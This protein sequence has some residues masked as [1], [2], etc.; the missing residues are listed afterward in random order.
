MKIPV[1][2]SFSSLVTGTVKNLQQNCSFHHYSSPENDS[3]KNQTPHIC[4][5]CN[6]TTLD[7]KKWNDNPSANAAELEMKKMLKHA[8][9]NSGTK[10]C[11][12]SRKPEMGLPGE[13]SIPHSCR[14][15]EKGPHPQGVWCRQLTLMQESVV[16]PT[17]QTH[18][19]RSHGD[20]FTIAPRLP[21]LENDVVGSLI[22]SKLTLVPFHSLYPMKM[23]TRI[24][25]R[26][27]LVLCGKCMEPTEKF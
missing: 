13:L 12:N 8:A 21:F 22:W 26:L 1:N 3:Q 7:P 27:I 25:I 15:R 19:Y 17:A 4:K 18:D 11:I 16:H 23:L 24:G 2:S 6:F 9:E 14:D 10:K 20:S 5:F